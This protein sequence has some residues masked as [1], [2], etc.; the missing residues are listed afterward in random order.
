[1][2]KSVGHVI[3]APITKKLYSYE[4]ALQW[5]P[6]QRKG[7]E[8]YSHIICVKA[9]DIIIVSFYKISLKSFLLSL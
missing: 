3:S 9:V 5:Q 8:C 1:M 2:G 7:F 6:K 4:F